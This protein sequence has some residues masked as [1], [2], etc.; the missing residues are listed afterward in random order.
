MANKQ[1][2]VEKKEIGKGINLA[3]RDFKESIIGLINS[4]GLPAMLIQYI[5]NDVINAMNNVTGQAIEKENEDYQKA[6]D[7]SKNKKEKK[8]ED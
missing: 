3:G 4:S 2:I 7:E 8:E 5:L 6:L 1:E